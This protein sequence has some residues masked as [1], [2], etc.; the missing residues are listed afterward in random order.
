[1]S[2]LADLFVRVSCFFVVLRVCACSFVG[3]SFDCV[4]VYM[5]VYVCVVRL[6]DRLLVCMRVCARVCF[7]AWLF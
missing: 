2:V 5:L 1:M 6:R 7:F 3:L 4:L